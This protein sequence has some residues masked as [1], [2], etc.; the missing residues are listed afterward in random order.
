MKTA[1]YARVSTEDQTTDNQSL[2]LEEVAKKM[3]WMYV[4]RNLWTWSYLN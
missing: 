2:V 3:E 4:V 1:I